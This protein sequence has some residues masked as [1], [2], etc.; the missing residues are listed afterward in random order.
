MPMRLV[1]TAN[2]G[3]LRTKLGLE[4]LKDLV[5]DS[6]RLPFADCDAHDLVQPGV[7]WRRGFEKRR[8]SEVIIRWS[9]P[10]TASDP[11]THLRRSMPYSTI[12]DED[13]RSVVG[14]QDQAHILLKRP[15]CT[16]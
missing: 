13:Q 2:F 4:N 12:S 8:C 10:F 14:S 7:L 9:N 5:G 15:V 6:V 3:R 16:N 1:T 11:S